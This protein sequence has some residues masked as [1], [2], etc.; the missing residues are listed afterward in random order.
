MKHA[1]DLIF[2]GA[3]IGVLATGVVGTMFFLWEFK[4]PI[5]K[6]R[7]PEQDGQFTEY[8]RRL[9]AC[10]WLVSTLLY[11]SLTYWWPQ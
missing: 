10:V 9:L 1:F 6:G 8:F 11:I 5:L 3:I 4:R 2:C 7:T